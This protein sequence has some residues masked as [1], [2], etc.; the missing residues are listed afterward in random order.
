[1]K[2]IYI[3]STLLLYSLTTLAQKAEPFKATHLLYA[4]ERLDIKNLVVL[5]KDYALV[6]I[7]N[8]NT[9]TSNRNVDFIFSLTHKTAT[10]E[11]LDSHT[12]ILLKNGVAVDTLEGIAYPT[13]IKRLNDDLYSFS[14]FGTYHE[15]RINRKEHKIERVRDLLPFEPEVT[16]SNALKKTWYMAHWG[17]LYYGRYNGYSIGK[18]RFHGMAGKK[19]KDLPIFFVEGLE[20]RKKTYVNPEEKRISKHKRLL[21]GPNFYYY[22][23]TYTYHH[24][25]IFF[26]V[27]SVNKC[28]IFDTQTEKITSFSFPPINHSQ[29][30]M[31]VYDF[32]AEKE[33]V[34][35]R[36]SGRKYEL[37]SLSK[38][39]T[40]VRK[41][42]DLDFMP[43]QIVDNHVLKEA[44][45]KEGDQEFVA[46]Y[47]IPL[48]FEE[49]RRSNLM[50][51][52]DIE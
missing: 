50:D 51:A 5:D 33:Y 29:A 10:K 40:S 37:F 11:K 9:K 31:Y 20:S 1:M 46:Y 44:W 8:P 45:V 21:P 7:P 18:K 24:G 41:L 16:N 43:L 2:I 49:E 17:D 13:G 27:V 42:A 25:K 4:N 39:Y 28:Y 3:L 14:G 47:L 38:D 12:L 15:I 35:R 36:R 26:N 30:C 6:S 22:A 48:L 52:V 34:V 32:I 23:G 19:R